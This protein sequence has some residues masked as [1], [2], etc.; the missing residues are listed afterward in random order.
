MKSLVDLKIENTMEPLIQKC[1]VVDSLPKNLDILLGQD[2][3][4]KAGYNIQ[5]DL[6]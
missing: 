2:W 1:Y 5:K 3:L 6:I 4:G